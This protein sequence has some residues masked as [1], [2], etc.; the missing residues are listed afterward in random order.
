[1]SLLQSHEASLIIPLAEAVWHLR[2]VNVPHL[3]DRIRDEATGKHDPLSEKTRRGLSNTHA[4]LVC[5]S[6]MNACVYMIT[7]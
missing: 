7:A 6:C 1:M 4:W 3:C 2:V 5:V